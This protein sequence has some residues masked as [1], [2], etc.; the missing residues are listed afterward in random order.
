MLKRVLLILLMGVTFLVA[1]TIDSIDI[2]GFDED[3]LKPIIGIKVGDNYSTSKVS[4]A[5]KI[6][7]QV[8]KSAGYQE[9]SVSSRLADKGKAVGVTFDVKKGEK[10]TITKVNFVGNK[11]VSSANLGSNLVNKEAEF[12][13]WFPGRSSGSAN[14]LQLKYDSMR[15]KDEYYKRGYLD[16]QVSEPKMKVDPKTYD[17]TITYKVKEGKPYKVSKV[18]LK[19]GKIKGVTSTEL[20]LALSLESGKI[21]DVSKL[22]KDIKILSQ[23]LGDA[24][25]AYAKVAPQFRKNARK[26]TMAVTYH[27]KAGPQVVIG[28]VIIKGNTKTK[29]HVV[30]R[31]VELA[32]GD[33]YSYSEYKASQR[34]LARTGYFEKTTIKPK[35]S[36]KNKIDLEVEVKETK[37]GAFTF[38]GG[39]GSADGW[40]VNGSVSERNLFGTGIE[41]SVSVDYSKVTQ[42]YSISFKEPRLFDSKYSLAAGIFKKESDYSESDTYSNLAYQKKDEIGGYLSMGKQFTREIYASIGYSYKDV[43]YSDVNTSY[44]GD[45]YTNYIKSSLIASLVYDSTDDYYT[46]REGIYAK[47]NL[48]YAGV[49]SASSGKDFAE[50]TKY[51]FKFA[52]YY[53]VQDSIDYDLILRYKLRASYIDADSFTSKYVPIAERLYLGGARRGIRGFDSASIA[54]MTGD[55]LTGGDRSYVHSI[56]ASIPLSVASKM[57]LTFFADYGQIGAGKFDDA[58]K[59]VG[60]QVEWRSPFGPI[61]LIFAKAIDAEDDDKTTSFEFSMGTKF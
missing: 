23:K 13:G 39:Y 54:P 16:A 51:N 1:K 14:V 43:E 18:G 37:T 44:S 56:E 15:V 4:K 21:F 58:K 46:P 27:V 53:G 40:L 42:S 6:I 60:A 9:S 29:D 59:S 24:G 12:M 35:K 31:Y 61:N 45:E 2:K 19:A 32:P 26:H 30:R 10:I 38:G 50:F 11:N 22:R 48:E 47:L 41:A 7:I 57:R 33:M 52:A 5:K 28:D 20:K 34:A 55:F 49:G 8:L 36:S 25:Y 17:A 3:K